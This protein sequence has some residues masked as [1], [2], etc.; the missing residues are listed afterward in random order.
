[1]HTLQTMDDGEA[2]AAAT[3]DSSEPPKLAPT[4]GDGADGTARELPITNAAEKMEEGSGTGQEATVQAED[5]AAAVED[6][7]TRES[8]D[9]LL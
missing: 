1:M 5:N 7:A 8:C 6:R 9:V 2:G 3:P 4:D